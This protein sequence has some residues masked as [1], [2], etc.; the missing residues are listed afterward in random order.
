MT[1]RQIGIQCGAALIEK[2]TFEQLKQGLGPVLV[3]S[4]ES[5][6]CERAN[7][8]EYVLGMYPTTD[9]CSLQKHSYWGTSVVHTRRRR[10]GW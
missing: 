5:L 1:R 8:Q 2:R 6:I 7:C 4:P 9:V 10:G 3:T